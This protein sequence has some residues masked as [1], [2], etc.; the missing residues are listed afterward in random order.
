MARKCILDLNV[1]NEETNDFLTKH[2]IQGNCLSSVKIGLRYDNKLVALATFGKVRFKGHTEGWEL[3]RYCN[4]D[5]VIGGASRIYN[6]FLKIYDPTVVLSYADRRWSQGN[7]YYSLGFKLIGDT[8]PNYWYFKTKRRF[9][10][11]KFTKQKLIK[12][13]HDGNLTERQI[14]TENGYQRIYDCGS[15]KFL[16]SR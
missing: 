12:E 8:P 7:L 11:L 10:R 3:L 13:G 16:W 5:H 15:L 6:N 1:S 9:H 4:I 14:M 2:H